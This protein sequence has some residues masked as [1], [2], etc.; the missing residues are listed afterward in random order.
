MQSTTGT[1]SGIPAQYIE[2]ATT[3]MLFKELIKR[4]NN[5]VF[6]YEADSAECGY[7]TNDVVTKGSLA[8]GLGLVEWGRLH[9]VNR[10]EYMIDQ[11]NID[12]DA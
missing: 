10:I 11:Q 5:F 1:E 9:F 4:Y 6:I 2:L 7:V 12:S 8:T 3:D